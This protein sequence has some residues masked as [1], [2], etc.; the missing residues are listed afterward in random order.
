MK[1][2]YKVESTG[3]LGKGGTSKE[4]FMLVER[5]AQGIVVIAFL[6]QK[7]SKYGKGSLIKPLALPLP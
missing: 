1:D 6:L 7:L 4:L 5:P 3:P 2:E